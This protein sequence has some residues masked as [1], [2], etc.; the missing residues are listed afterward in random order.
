MIP[1][2]FDYVRPGSLEEALAELADPEAK[3][4][5][6]GH[7]LLPMMKLRL[8]RPSRLVDLAGLGLTGL[9]V[10]GDTIRIG[11]LTTYDELLSLGDEIPLP[12]ALRDAASDVG[13]V[14][15]RNAGTVGGALAH[16]DPASDFAAA[17]IATGTTLLARSPEGEREVAAEQFF[18]GPFTTLLG[19]QELLLE[20]RV[21]VPAAG[22]G[23]AYVAFED[24][25]SGYPLAGAAVRVDSEGGCTV[26]LTGIA[27]QPLR[28]TAVEEALEA[29]AD[30]GEALDAA[31][32]MSLDGDPDHRRQLAIVAVDRARDRARGRS[33]R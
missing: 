21:P 10:D 1:A 17:V 5:A 3:A 16:G 27:A 6:G 31:G 14:Q 19:Q 8:A 24:P 25:A 22:E 9:T 18:L 33:G 4:I 26:G 15:V 32:L 12:G 7:S 20:L 28:A 23:S 2:A 13:D 29:G 11:A 30:L